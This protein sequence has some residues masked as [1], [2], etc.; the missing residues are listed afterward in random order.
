MG[1][2]QAHRSER[3]EGQRLDHPALL[4]APL[5]T[6]PDTDADRVPRTTRDWIV[7]VVCFLLAAGMGAFVAF[8]SAQDRFFS[9]WL[10]VADVAIGALG[11]LSMWWRRRWPVTIA[12]LLALAGT[13]FT[14]SAGAAIIAM[15][16]VAVHRRFTVAT[17]VAVV[18]ALVALPFYVV[19]PD[20]GLPYLGSVGFTVALVAT[21]TGWG[22]FVRARRQLVVS[23]RERAHRAEAEQQL[24]AEQTRR[25]ERERIA[26]EMHDVLAHRISLLST[27][28]G[29][30]EYRRDASPE[31]VARA[32]GV[33]RDSSHQALQHLRE[34]IGVLRENNAP[35]APSNGSSTPERP[36][37][38]LSDL[39]WL[40]EE[41]RQAGL[42]VTWEDEIDDAQAAPAGVGRAAYRIVQEGLTNVHKHAPDTAV[43]VR[44]YGGPG[45][46]LA[47]EIRN[48]L[49]V[50]HDTEPVT[51]G[52]GS[53]LVGL[54]ERANLAGGHLEHGRD[55]DGD[56]RVRAWLPWPS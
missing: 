42:R 13:V 38:T 5:L 27:Y 36:Q 52:T 51:P 22:M 45:N 24:R 32:A 2:P 44:A 15:F 6:D 17:L 53:G 25:A 8:L 18:H 54:T 20:P 41:S 16:T 30:L 46:G 3:T 34:V 40:I 35:A 47:V 12:L 37:P 43:T 26:R 39:P 19:H 14:L 7:D 50:G 49:P 55:G 31:D 23:L 28:A 10:F 56:F 21:F 48:R 1:S 9:G 29:A 33:I 4:P 11:C